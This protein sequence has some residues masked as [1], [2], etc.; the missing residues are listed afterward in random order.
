MKK[1]SSTDHA[2]HPANKKSQ[3]A[4]E[5]LLTYGWVILGV[6]IT[7][8]ALAYFGV[9]NTDRFVNDECSFGTQLYCEDVEVFSGPNPDM[10]IQFRNNFGQDIMITGMD[11]RYGSDSLSFDG[12]AFGSDSTP[13]GDIAEFQGILKEVN[14][15]KNEK[16]KL[17]VI[18]HF[19]R[20]VSGA[21]T[22]NVTGII[23]ATTK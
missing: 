19:E 13:A 6:M 9:F 21:P 10:S 12:V 18:V 5:F 7:V 4:V 15:P 14:F 20:D 1:Y 11:I 22:H 2:N 8:G 23:I 3:A 17:N 16:I